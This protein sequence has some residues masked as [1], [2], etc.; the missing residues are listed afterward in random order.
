MKTI[1]TQRPTFQPQVP[2]G[3]ELGADGHKLR[4]KNELEAL[5]QMFDSSILCSVG[6]GTR[7]FLGLQFSSVKIPILVGLK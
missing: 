1:A 7:N 4:H 2:S 5:I 3:T 6:S